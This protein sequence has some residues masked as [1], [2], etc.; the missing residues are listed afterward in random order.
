[1]HPAVFDTLSVGASPL[2][3]SATN[4]RMESVLQ[5]FYAA[6][7]MAEVVVLDSQ[8]EGTREAGRQVVKCSCGEHLNA[9]FS[10][11]IVAQVQLLQA[12]AVSEKAS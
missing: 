3:L 11:P 9:F 1:M 2:V 12:R 8:P 7:R 4:F 6:F 5:I 10:E